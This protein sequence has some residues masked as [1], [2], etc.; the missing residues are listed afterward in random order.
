MLAPPV[1][2]SVPRADSLPALAAREREFAARTAALAEREDRIAEQ[3]R[4]LLR[5][6]WVARGHAASAR[7]R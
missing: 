5:E 3:Q 6:R 1:R 2:A 4:A 7:P